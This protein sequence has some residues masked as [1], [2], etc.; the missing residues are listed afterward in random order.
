[1]IVLVGTLVMSVMP[2][3]G[4]VRAGHSHLDRAGGLAPNG[5]GPRRTLLTHLRLE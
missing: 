5:V 1:M 3:G 2:E 4:L